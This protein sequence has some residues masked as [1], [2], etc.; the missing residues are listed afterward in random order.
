MEQKCLS[1]S[2]SQFNKQAKH[3]KSASSYKTFVEIEL[4]EHANQTFT[5]HVKL[6]GE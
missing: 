3:S 1:I 4:E 5:T 2:K 6:E